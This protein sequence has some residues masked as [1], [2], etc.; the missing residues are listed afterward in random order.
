MRK[1]TYHPSTVNPSFLHV[2][3][4]GAIKGWISQTG[5]KTHRASIYKQIVCC[6]GTLTACKGKIKDLV[7]QL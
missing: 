7:D 1:V 4:D 2:K 3:V 6:D 5:H